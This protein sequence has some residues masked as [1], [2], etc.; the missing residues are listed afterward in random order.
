MKS[1]SRIV[2]EAKKSSS[3][4]YCPDRGDIIALD[5]SPQA[6]REQAGA[7]PALVLTERRYNTYARLCIACPITRTVRGGRLEVAVPP[8]ITLPDGIGVIDGVLNGE[9]HGVLLSD[10]AKSVSWTERG[11]VFIGKMPQPTIDEVRARLA[12]LLDMTLA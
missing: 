7:R 1:L 12:A 2:Q 9:L 8:G 11:S 10:H 4:P 3:G 5:F 6:G